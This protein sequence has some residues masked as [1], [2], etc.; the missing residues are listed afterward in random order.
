VASLALTQREPNTP[1]LA[2]ERIHLAGGHGDLVARELTVPELSLSRG[3]LAATLARDGTV[4]WQKLVVTPPASTDPNFE[5]IITEFRI[6]NAV[7]PPEAVAKSYAL[8]E[9]AVYPSAN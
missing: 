7:L 5:G 4:N 6:Y 9:D 1:L 3:R 8:G 2:L